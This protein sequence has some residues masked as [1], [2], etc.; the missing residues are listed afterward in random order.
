MK[1]TLSHRDSRNRLVVSTRTLDQLLERMRRDNASHRVARFREAVPHL[2]DGG[3]HYKALPAWPHVCAAAEWTKDPQGGLRMKRCNGVLT[4]IFGPL[5][6]EGEV[7]TVKRR[8]AMLPAT[9]AAVE[10]A[11]GRSVVVLV[12]Y[13]PLE[14]ELPLDEEEAERLHRTA[15]DH[16]CPVYQAA[17]R[18]GTTA[19]QPALRDTFLLTL[20]A[21]PL[22]NPEAVPMKVDAHDPAAA[23]CTPSVTHPA[24]PAEPADGPDQRSGH[25]QRMM[26]LLR[27]RYVLRYNT[28][29]HYDEYMLKEKPWHGFLPLDPRAQKRMTL[30]VQLAGIQVSIR[31]VRNF[32]ESDCIPGFNPI[33]DYLAQCRGQW[34]GTDRIRAL[35]R[36]VP[37]ELEGWTEWFYTWF[38]AMVNQWSGNPFRRYGNSVAPLLISS[39]GYNKSTFCRSLLPP[40]LQWGY[41]DNINLADKRQVFQAM[42]QQLL[43]NLDEFN[44]ISPK[45]QQ[46]FLKNLIQL[47]TVKMKR[48]YG[49]HVE[50]FPRLASFVA[51][52]NMYDILS[53]PSGNRRFIGVEL[54]GPIDVSV[55]PDHRQLFAQALA[56][57][58]ARE[59]SYFDDR[60]VQRIMQSNL[61][62]ETEQPAEQFFHLYFEPAPDEEGG[63]YL[64]TAEIFTLLRR[65]AGVPLRTEN[66]MSLGRRLSHIPGLLRRRFETGT[67]YLVRRKR[68]ESLS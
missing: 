32:L 40:E 50:E 27:D 9:L 13:A 41:I 7:E 49:C 56:A 60:Q 44:Q 37:T 42:S 46:G 4:L 1:M 17:L 36:T 65:Q 3:R 28:V 24:A 15:S 6:Q 57:L 58:A 19:G 31:D 10:G 33:D 51:T 55:R 48:P 23:S 39:Q 45:V 63:E 54:T 66:M 11:D 12:R 68:P 22:H 16:I 52:S 29:M 38:L 61:R 2:D 34:D 14:G 8:A 26:E 47:P 30:E 43:V 25:I 20:D 62:Y 64:S 59:Q 18:C 67:K 5:L 35:A 21:S 53:D